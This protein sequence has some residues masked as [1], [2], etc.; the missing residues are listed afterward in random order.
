MKSEAVD[1]DRR[2]SGYCVV[3]SSKKLN[4]TFHLVEVV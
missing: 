3:F 4:G 1:L 2:G